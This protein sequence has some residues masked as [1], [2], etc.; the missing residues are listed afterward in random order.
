MATL[1]P[2]RG[3]PAGSPLSRWSGT[4]SVAAHAQRWSGPLGSFLLFRSRLAGSICALAL[5]AL[6]G[7]PAAAEEPTDVIRAQ[8]STRGGRPEAAVERPTTAPPAAASV[9][10]RNDGPVHVAVGSAGA[11]AVLVPLTP[12]EAPQ[13]PA[14]PPPAMAAPAAP[15]EP[16]PPPAPSAPSVADQIVA[17]AARAVGS[18]YVW[19]GAS[20]VTGFDCSGL[21]Q[22]V[23]AQ[24]GVDRGRDVWAQY[25]GGDPIA[26]E[27]LEPGDLVFFAN[28]Y[29]PGLSHVGIY[30][31]DGAFVD[32]GTERTGVRQASL[33]SPYWASRYVGAR[34]ARS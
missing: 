13:V 23:L 3:R 30:V 29:Q 19:G 1:L 27:A 15:A 22:W 24:V 32:A 28:T 10:G 11:G 26:R 6:T 31:G 5:V 25:Q 17:H 9:D 7:L 14:V 4:K 20:P 21:V 2:V 34:R 16:V 8:P 33:S 12:M 18:P